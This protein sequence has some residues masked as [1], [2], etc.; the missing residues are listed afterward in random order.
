MMKLLQTNGITGRVAG[1]KVKSRDRIL[2]KAKAKYSGDAS[3][4]P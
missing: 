4:V 1:S 3:S 2:A